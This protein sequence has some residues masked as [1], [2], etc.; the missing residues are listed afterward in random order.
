MSTR[1]IGGVIM[2]HGDDDGLRVPPAIAP[3]QIVIIPMLREAPE[4]ADLIAYCEEVRA[5]LA[6]R[7]R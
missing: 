1:L 3:Q 6:S 2:T 4:D 7:S 5:A